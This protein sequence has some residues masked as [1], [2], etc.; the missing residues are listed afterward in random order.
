MANEVFEV[1]EA[2]TIPDGKHTGIIKKVTIENR[3]DPKTKETY[4]YVDLHCVIDGVPD[5]TLRA[6]FPAKITEKTGLGQLLRRFGAKVEV[7][8][9]IDPVSF[10]TGKKVVFFTEEETN[11]RGTFSRIDNNSIIPA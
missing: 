10:L 7:G 5:I 9:K 2:V 4:R 8:A 6:G 1:E 11:T 3:A